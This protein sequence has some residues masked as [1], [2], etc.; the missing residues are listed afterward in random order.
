LGEK[1]SQLPDC[2][3]M[4]ISCGYNYWEGLKSIN[5]PSS[6]SKRHNIFSS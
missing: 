4:N 1:I 3:V 5:R 6:N 2:A